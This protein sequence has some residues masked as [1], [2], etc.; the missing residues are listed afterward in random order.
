VATFDGY[1]LIP[2][3]IDVQFVEPSDLRDGGSVEP[4]GVGS[5]D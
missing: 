3:T 1:D 4:L 2:R 5:T